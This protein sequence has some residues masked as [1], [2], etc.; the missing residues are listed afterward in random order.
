MLKIIALSISKRPK[1]FKLNK[2][3]LNINVG[4]GVGG[5]KIDDKNVSN[6]KKM[7]SEA[8]FLIFKAK[9]AFT[10]L[11]KAFTK[12]PILYYFGS[13]HHI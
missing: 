4:D 3:N 8:S 5:R 7:S 10:P 9:L 1:Q 2:K 6:T 11:K 12:V 13:D